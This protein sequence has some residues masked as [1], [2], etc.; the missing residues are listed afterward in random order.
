MQALKFLCDHKFSADGAKVQTF[1]KGH[2]QKFDDD[3]A[4]MLLETTVKIGDKEQKVVE[5]STAKKAEAAKEQQED[6]AVKMPGT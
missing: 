6:S 1:E 5:K 2:V 3:V 4:E